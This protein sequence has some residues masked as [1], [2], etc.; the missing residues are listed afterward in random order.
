VTTARLIGADQAP[1][2]ARPYDAG[3]GPGPIVAAL[4][5][6]PEV[7]QVAVPFIGAA[8][9][10]GDRLGAARRSSSCAPPRWPAATTA[11]RPTP[12]SPP[13]PPWTAGRD[14]AAWRTA[15]RAGLHPPR[16]S[17]PC[18]GESTRSGPQTAPRMAASATTCRRTGRSR[19]GRADH[20]RRGHPAAQPLCQRTGVTH[21]QRHRRPAHPRRTAVTTQE[22]QL[23]EAI[24][25]GAR[26]RTRARQPASR[27]SS[28]WFAPPSIRRSLRV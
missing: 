13:T 25:L 7:L 12:S 27:G 2:L 5:Q 19:G 11:W 16:A 14:R 21:L 9:G 17:P 20:R 15:D 28:T 24:L 4:A 8:L 22:T 23:D 10:L 18:C 1:L 26:P 6:V 3:G